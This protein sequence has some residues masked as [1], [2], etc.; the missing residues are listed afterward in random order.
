MENN[1]IEEQSA[2]EK[3]I[4]GMLEMLE[5]GNVEGF[6]NDIDQ[7]AASKAYLVIR[8]S[9]DNKHVKTIRES[10]KDNYQ[11]FQ[12]IKL[13]AKKSWDYDHSIPT[14][15]DVNRACMNLYTL[16]LRLMNAQNNDYLRELSKIQ[17][18]INKIEEKVG[19]ESTV[20]EEDQ[21]NLNDGGNNDV[22]DVQGVK[23]NS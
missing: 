17:Q 4:N 9:I 21:D 11:K 5:S 3:R 8:D 22:S 1:K 13:R 20:W 6:L 19:L 18:A 10:G 7:M 2:M 14:M 12:D 15:E 23:E 16:V